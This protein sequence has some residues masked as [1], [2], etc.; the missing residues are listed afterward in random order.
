MLKISEIKFKKQKVTCHECGK[1]L[2]WNYK[3]FKRINRFDTICIHCYN[4]RYHKIK[5]TIKETKPA[6]LK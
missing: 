6:P 1:Q 3:N 5:S 4:K 2:E